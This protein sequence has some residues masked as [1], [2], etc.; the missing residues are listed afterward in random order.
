MKESK[1]SIDDWK[2]LYDVAME[3]KKIQ[4]WEWMYDSD[5]FGVQN[6]ANGEIGY[7]SVMGNLGEFFALGIYL[8]TEGLETYIR[9]RNGELEAGNIESLTSQKC[10]MAS[11]EDRDALTDKDREII[12]EL[13]LKFRGHNE[14]PL[15]RDY[16]PGYYPW[17]MTKDQI[18]YMI[19]SLQQAIEIAIRFKENRDI[20]VS[21]DKE[22]FFVR[23][24]KKT[25]SGLQWKDSWLKPEPSEKPKKMLLKIEESSLEEIKSGIVKSGS[26]WE[27]DVFQTSMSVSEKAGE[28]PY[29][30]YM[31]LFV[32]GEMGVP[33]SFGFADQGNHI[34]EFIENFFESMEKLGVP[35]KIRV[36]RRETYE[37]LEIIAGQLEIDLKLVKKL[38][39]ME[40]VQDFVLGRMM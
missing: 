4:C 14:W 12:K 18:Q 20:L 6:P 32:D 31:I 39:K 5:V 2:A 7:C 22:S 27:V 1:T 30:P 3:F 17:Y 29:Y 8:G 36:R 40:A 24:P 37:I 23:V 33:I 26:T 16:T 13:G 10:L 34:K 28:R 9:I 38:S 35:S 11:F 15:F 25:K 19:I 21:P